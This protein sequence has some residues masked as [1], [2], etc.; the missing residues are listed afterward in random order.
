VKPAANEPRSIGHSPGLPRDD[1]GPVF[2][3]PWQA[4]AFALAVALHERGAFTWSEW[5][6]A[7]GEAIGRAQAAGDPDDGSRYYHHWLDALEH[8]VQ[9]KRL[10]DSAELE[11]LAIAWSDAAARTPH[12][13]PIELDGAARARVRGG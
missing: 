6:Q 7:L 4:Q 5:A 2:A 3:A 10:G 11:A 1:H 8:L 9:T 13:Q 12:G